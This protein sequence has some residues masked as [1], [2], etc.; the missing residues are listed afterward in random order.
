MKYKSGDKVLVRGDVL[1][2]VEDG[3]KVSLIDDANNLN[4]MWFAEEQLVLDKTNVETIPQEEIMKSAYEK[5]LNDAWKLVYKIREMDYAERI[6]AFDND[7]L[8]EILRENTPQ[9]A[10]AKLK[11]YEDSKIKVG[12]VVET[13]DL[14]DVFKGV[15]LD[16]KDNTDDEVVLCLMKMVVLMCGK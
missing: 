1:G 2:V 6:K 11:A 10:I 14:I 5:G 13:T 15:V 8:F 4:T 12:D 16:F 9:E 7:A 3:I